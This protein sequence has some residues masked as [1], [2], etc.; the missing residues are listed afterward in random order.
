MGKNEGLAEWGAHTPAPR[1]AYRGLFCSVDGCEKPAKCRGMCARHYTKAM[2]AAGHRPPSTRSEKRL[3]NR[4]K[5]RY[6]I[7][8]AE[9]DRLLSEQNGLCAICLTDGSEGRPSH[10]ITNLVPD[11]N[12]D[13]GAVRGLLCNDCNRIAGRTRDTAILERAIEYVRTRY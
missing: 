2:W 5:W 7:D 4:R 11:H 13:T 8:Q 12:H 1:G 9:F 3:S 6:G 10:W